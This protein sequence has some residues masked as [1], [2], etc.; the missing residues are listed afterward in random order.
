MSK[1]G[2]QPSCSILPV[3]KVD[4]LCDL[5]LPSSGYPLNTEYYVENLLLYPILMGFEKLLKSIFGIPQM[6]ESDEVI[7]LRKVSRN[8]YGKD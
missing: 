4:F 8:M 3:E 7:P 5:E 6:T 2:L 1:A